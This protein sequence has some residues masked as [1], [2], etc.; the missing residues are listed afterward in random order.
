MNDETIGRV[1]A[2]GRRRFLSQAGA[3]V[4]V[5]LAGGYALRLE[6]TVA[7]HCG[8]ARAAAVALGRR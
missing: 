2:I 1:D 8:T 7:I 6:D 3:A 5:L 4:A